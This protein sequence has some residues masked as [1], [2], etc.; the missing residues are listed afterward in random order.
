MRLGGERSSGWF[1]ETWVLSVNSKSSYP[2][3]ITA[4]AIP[5]LGVMDAVQAP[6]LVSVLLFIVT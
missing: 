3:S 1:V 6:F 5:A 4:G 2:K